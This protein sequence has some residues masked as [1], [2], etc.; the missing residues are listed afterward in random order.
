MPKHLMTLYTEQIQQPKFDC[1]NHART[2]SNLEVKIL[3][4]VEDMNCTEMSFVR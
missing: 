3:G 2:C 4:N 1:K